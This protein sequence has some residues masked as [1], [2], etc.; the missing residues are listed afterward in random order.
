M[1]GFWAIGRHGRLRGLL[2]SYVDGQVSPRQSLQVEEHL[3]GC[4]ECRAELESLRATVALLQAL[5]QLDLPRSFALASPPMPARA[6]PTYFWA[7]GLA[8]SVAALLLVAVVVADVFEVIAQPEAVQFTA[9]AAPETLLGAPEA[10]AALAAPRASVAEEAAAAAPAPALALPEPTAVTAP[11]LAPSPVPSP[12]MAAAAPRPAADA[13]APV[14]PSPAPP[15]GLAAA[16]APA[17]PS[18]VAAVERDAAPAA[19]LQ[20]AAPLAAPPP[21]SSQT[22]AAATA[23]TLAAAPRAPAA[24]TTPCPAPT[25][26][27]RQMALGASVAESPTPPPQPTTEKTVQDIAGAAETA[28]PAVAAQLAAASRTP[29]EVRVVVEGETAILPE[30]SPTPAPVAALVATPAPTP[31]LLAPELAAPAVTRAVEPPAPMPSPSGSA[32]QP[33]APAGNETRLPLRELEIALG[34]VVALLLAATV[35][36]AARRRRL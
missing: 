22:P 10:A 29:D 20:A 18:P 25:P 4:D 13:V 9:A 15:S 28:T 31:L 1:I 35:W 34:A 19:A 2:S 32:P 17:A 12:A 36:L 33:A 6:R 27:P 3:S 8:T 30:A 24:M 11:R 5:P 23:E 26:Q 21:P 16:A 7:T 14:E